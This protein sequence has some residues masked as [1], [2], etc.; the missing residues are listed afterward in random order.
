MIHERVV[1]RVP[2]TALAEQSL[3]KVAD[4][5][6]DEQQ[7][8]EAS[9]AYDRYVEL[10]GRRY[11][12]ERA[13]LR[14]AQS[15]YSSYEGSAFDDTPLVESEQRFQTY[16]ANYPSQATRQE[17]PAVLNEIELRKARKDFQTAAFY[18]RIERPRPAAFYY[19]Q[20]MGLY[21]G[22]TF[23]DQA[24]A[25]LLRLNAP[26]VTDN[27]L[28]RPIPVPP[29]APKMDRPQIEMAPPERRGSGAPRP[30]EDLAP[31]FREGNM[32]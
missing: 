6:F 4:W 20:V 7:W 21:P 32:E 28:D 10:F 13:E 30:L 17:I 26:A 24:E 27:T 11:R 18:E 25:A 3:M 9:E 16:L 23:A 15:I 8:D 2:G 5:H 12:S 19:R 14:A 22:T 29:A 1:E 31:E